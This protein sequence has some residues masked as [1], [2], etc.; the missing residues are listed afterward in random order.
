MAAVRFLDHVPDRTR[1]EAAAARLGG[2]VRGQ[3]IVAVTEPIESTSDGPYFPWD[4]AAE[5]ESLARQWFS[6][7]EFDANLDRLV[8]SQKD[9]GS[10]PVRWPVWTPVTA[11]EWGG[12]VTID[13]IKVLVS[14]GRGS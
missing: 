10:W 13:A 9:D 5:A 3:R 4:Y 12:W 11:F 6:D 1:A 7:V 8:E 14:H 2:L